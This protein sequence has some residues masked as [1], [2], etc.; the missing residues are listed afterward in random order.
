[1]RECSICLKRCSCRSAEKFKVNFNDRGEFTSVMMK[2]K[3][4]EIITDIAR[5]SQIEKS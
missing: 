4:D 1:M 5:C 3:H 2:S